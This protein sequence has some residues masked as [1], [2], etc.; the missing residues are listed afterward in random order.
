[1]QQAEAVRVPNIGDFAGVEV[2]DVLVQVGDVIKPEDPLITLESDKATID[3][4]APAAG[5]ITEIKIQVGDKVSEG[6]LILMLE[7]GLQQAEEPSIASE[8]AAAAQRR[9]FLRTQHEVL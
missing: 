7:P 6:D 2:I 3:I 4:P 1:M 5:K 9:R 8:P